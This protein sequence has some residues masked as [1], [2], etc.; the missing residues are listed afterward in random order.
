MKVTFDIPDDSWAI[1]KNLYLFSGAELL[2]L[3][4][5]NYEKDK[6]DDGTLIRKKQYLP[7]RLKPNDGRCTGCGDCCNSGGPQQLDLVYQQFKMMDLFG[8][9]YDPRA[10]CPML[11]SEIGCTLGSAIP[12]SCVSSNCEGWSENCTE[13]L[14]PINDEA[15]I[16]AVI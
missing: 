10:P 16:L 9:K 3:L 14:V 6:Q 11:D 13:K 15:I 7:L 5:F 2:G 8:L 12:F 4:E 1:G